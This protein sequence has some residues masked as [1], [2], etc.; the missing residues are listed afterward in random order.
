MSYKLENFILKKKSFLIFYCHSYSED[1][2][3]FN[4]IEIFCLFIER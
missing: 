4:K 3:S 1:L 2:I